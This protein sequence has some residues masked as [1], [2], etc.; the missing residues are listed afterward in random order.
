MFIPSAAPLAVEAMWKPLKM[1]G[2]TVDRPSTVRIKSENGR[3]FITANVVPHGGL[4]ATIVPRP[5]WAIGLLE[6]LI[7]RFPIRLMIGR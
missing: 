4:G 3:S 1:F 2:S 5:N 6:N 7:V